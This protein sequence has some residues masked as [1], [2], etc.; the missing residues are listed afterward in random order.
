[1]LSFETKLEAKNFLLVE[2]K[3]RETVENL[4]IQTG[5]YYL[6]SG[7]A[8]RPDYKIRKYR[9]GYG[10]YCNFNFFKGT[11]TDCKNGRVAF[12]DGE[13]E[14]ITVNMWEYKAGL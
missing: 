7:Q 8:C 3:M 10:I 9:D 5:V 1:M 11:L 6:S 14:P 2:K 4:F 12:F 13:F